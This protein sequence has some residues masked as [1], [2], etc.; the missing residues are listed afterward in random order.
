MNRTGKKLVALWIVAI[1]LSL[2]G[3]AQAA[4]FDCKSQKLSSVEKQICASKNLSK[5]DDELGA[6]Y[7]AKREKAS[8]PRKFLLKWQQ[9]RWL[10]RR[11]KCTKDACISQL[12]HQR[13]DYLRHDYRYALVMSKNT[14]LCN[15]LF[16]TY[17]SDM[18][19]YGEIKYDSG[20]FSDI[21][22]NYG[23]DISF[24]RKATFDI[25]NDGAPDL[26]VLRVLPLFKT[27]AYYYNVF[28]EKSVVQKFG[29]SASN[30][31]PNLGQSSKVIFMRK[32]ALKSVPERLRDYVISEMK[33]LITAPVR[34]SDLN[35]EVGPPSVIME[36]FVWKGFTYLSMTD[37]GGQWVV[38]ARFNENYRVHDVCYYYNPDIGW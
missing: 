5:L 33:S 20:I 1:G 4:S 15:S 8:A 27:Y 31:I 18:S 13:I 22:W 24:G 21:S 3:L 6:L 17:N 14:K 11:N 35:I 36:P 7:K 10:G 37:S 9:L 16:E 29:D 32:Y 19:R 25:N 2:A 30:K 26:V 12:Y 23:A 28:S 34:S 38:V